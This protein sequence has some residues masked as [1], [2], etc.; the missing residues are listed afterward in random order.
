MLPYPFPQNGISGNLRGRG[1]GGILPK[2][3][4]SRHFR[5]YRRIVD[6]LPPGG[7]SVHQILIWRV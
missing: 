4:L 1:A 3:R 7:Q 6:K 5:N 2:M